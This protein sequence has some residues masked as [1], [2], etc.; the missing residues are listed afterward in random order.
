[1]DRKLEN[2]LPQFLREVREIKN[3]IGAEQLALEAIWDYAEGILPEFFLDDMTSYGVERW[4]S[5]L[6]INPK[7]IDTLEDRR[8]RI[9]TKL[10]KDLPYTKKNLELKLASICGS[11]GYSVEYDNDNYKIKIRI[12]LTVKSSID[13]VEQLLYRIVPANMVVDLSLMYNQHQLLSG[14]TYGRLGEYRHQ[15]LREEVMN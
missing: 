5:I 15:H 2:Y 9:K 3:I 14:Y 7:A 13:E 8:V 10:K 6:E 1:M 12:T 4:E 11:D